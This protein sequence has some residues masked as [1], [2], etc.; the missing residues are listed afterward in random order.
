MMIWYHD[1]VP[2]QVDR[3]RDA[4]IMTLTRIFCIQTKNQPDK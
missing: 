3:D 4:L 2:I 1:M